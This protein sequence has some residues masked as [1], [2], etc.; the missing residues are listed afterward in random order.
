MASDVY[1]RALSRGGYKAEHFFDVERARDYWTQHTSR[2]ELLK[3]VEYCNT[4]THYD[5]VAEPLWHKGPQAIGQIK[6]LSTKELEDVKA[7][8]DLDQTFYRF[9][10][11]YKRWRRAWVAWGDDVDAATCSDLKGM[12]IF[13]RRCDDLP[14]WRSKESKKED[15]KRAEQ[16]PKVHA[17]RAKQQRAWETFKKAMQEMSED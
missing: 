11:L 12:N 10:D 16:A 3:L 7:C 5:K 17:K 6:G 13:T 15:A 14:D 8:Y 9:A 4:E 1:K 2:Q